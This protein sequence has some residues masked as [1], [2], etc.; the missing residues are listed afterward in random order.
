M[1]FQ[2]LFSSYMYVVKAAKMMSVQKTCAY[3][4]DEIDCRC[5]N[6]ASIVHSIVNK[7]QILFVI[8]EK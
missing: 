1:L 4:V 5:D 8:V 3:D 6:A 7:R 2:Q